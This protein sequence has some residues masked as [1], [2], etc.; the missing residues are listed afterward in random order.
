MLDGS[1]N[2]P[3]APKLA[4][5]TPAIDFS[6]LSHAAKASASTAAKVAHP[7]KKRS[8]PSP[9]ASN[10]ALLDFTKPDAVLQGIQHQRIKP[11][12]PVQP[13]E[14]S[15]KL[16]SPIGTFIYLSRDGGSYGLQ[17]TRTPEGKFLISHVDATMIPESIRR[18]I[19]N[20]RELFKINGVR[21]VN[22]DQIKKAVQSPRIKLLL[23]D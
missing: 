9:P 5:G 23:R 10:A 16:V 19:W 2:F 3:A 15:V 7:K 13:Q 22:V 4:V 1:N 21:V 6:M 17:F 8:K 20:G 14:T 12:S 11:Q 18:H